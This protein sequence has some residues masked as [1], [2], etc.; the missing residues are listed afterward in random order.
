MKTK[1]LT[2]EQWNMIPKDEETQVTAVEGDLATMI[3]G[4]AFLIQRKNEWNNVVC[5]RVYPSER[6]IVQ[7]FN[8]FREYCAEKEIQ[9][10]RVEGISH[11]YKMLHLVC[12]L[13]R[14][15]GAD[16]NVIFHKTESAEYDRH[17]YYVKA[18]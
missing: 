12:R 5:I 13:G 11:T 9:F 17:I 15:L 14:K 8:S 3:D 1:L 2:I 10:F 6:S 18:Y 7:T 4:V 16:C